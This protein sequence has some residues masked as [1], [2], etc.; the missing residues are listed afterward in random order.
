LKHSFGFYLGII[1][2]FVLGFALI[3]GT[4]LGLSSEKALGYTPSVLKATKTGANTATLDLSTYPD[5]QVC[6]VGA[7]HPQIDWVTYC[8]STNFEVPANSTITVTI[9]NYDGQTEL[10]ND[11]FS[12][13]QGTVGNV[14]TVNGKTVSQVDATTVSHTFTIQSKPGTDHPLFISVPVVGVAD[15][16]ATDPNTGYPTQPEVI[17]FQFQTGPAGTTYIFKCY[18]PCGNGLQGDQQGFAGPMATI[19][20]MAGFVNV[21]SY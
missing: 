19:G 2:A 9:T 1:C 18:D 4:W 10:H 13:V 11:F 14:E 5:S 7:D 17:S 21:T 16:A 8:P 15:D 3:A 12:Q 6:H 20:Y